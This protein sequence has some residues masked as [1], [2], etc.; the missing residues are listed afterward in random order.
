[1]NDFV[2]Y[3]LEEGVCTLTLNRPEALNALNPEVFSG[4]EAAA[5]RLAADS[6]EVHCVILRGAGK[7]FCAGLDLKSLGPGAENPDLGQQAQVVEKIANL[8]MPVIAQVHSYCF[9]GALELALACDLIFVDE[10]TQLADTHS[11]WGLTPCWGM[12]QR[13]PRKVGRARAM[14]M[15]FSARRVAAAEALEI[16]LVERVFAVT[17]LA[18]QTRAYARQVASNSTLS[19]R[20]FKSLLSATDGMGL[21]EGLDYELVHSSG[22]TA[23]TA[24]RLDEFIDK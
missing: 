3:E 17:E 24:A 2:E 6:D 20:V 4:L 22:T 12:S 18:Q 21:A 1:M 23:D 10:N 9:A 5:D 15:M 7:A 8:P 14:D 16:G 19:H 11:K 13:L